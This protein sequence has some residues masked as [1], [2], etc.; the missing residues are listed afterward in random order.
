MSQHHHTKVLPF[1]SD[2]PPVSQIFLTLAI[3]FVAT[4][5][6][7]FAA[8]PII[9]LYLDPYSTITD[10]PAHG[11]HALFEDEPV[12]WWEHMLKGL[13]SIGLVGF[14][15]WFFTLNPMSWWNVRTS[16]IMNGARMGT[17]NTGRDRA[18]QVSWYV[19]AIGIVTVLWVSIAVV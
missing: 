16:G 19:V 9:N 1:S 7:G 6:L 4:F 13:A 10:I 18:Q 3:F 15:K 2:N 14:A 12:T 17:G 11:T 5:V 8:D